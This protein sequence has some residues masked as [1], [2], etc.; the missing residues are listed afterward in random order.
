MTGLQAVG[1]EK[2]QWGN[3]YE[4]HGSNETPF[5]YLRGEEEGVS[6]SENYPRQR[7]FR[8]EEGWRLF[9]VRAEERAIQTLKD[10]VLEITRQCEAIRKVYFKFDEEEHRLLI[11]IFAPNIGFEDDR[12]VFMAIL[13]ASEELPQVGRTWSSLTRLPEKHYKDEGFEI[14]PFRRAVH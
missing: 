2:G 11:D 1:S 9:L 7:L 10:E 6:S 5:W 13:A 8:G 4:L 3:D 14:H 12:D